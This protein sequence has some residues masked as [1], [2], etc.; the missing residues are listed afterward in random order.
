MNIVLITTGK[1]PDLLNQ[2]VV[3]LFENAADWESHTLTVV[4]DGNG[5]HG[6]I[7][8]PVGY[9]SIYATSRPGASAARNIG[10]GSIPKHRRQE[11]VLFLDDDV[12]MCKGWDE[13]LLQ[14]AN[15]EPCSIISG[16]GH[17]F[18][19]SELMV[20]SHD[21]GRVIQCGIGNVQVY[22]R[23]KAFF[24]RKPLVI[25]S[26]AMMMNWMAF[27]A[28]GPWDEPGGPGGSEDYALCMR[29]KDK[30]YGFA[31]TDPQ[32]VIH[33]GLISSKGEKIVG[34]QE[35]AEQNDKL[36]D[37]YGIRGKVQFG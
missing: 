14:L 3:S 24:Y 35:L 16:Y 22:D 29:A 12:Y 18:N 37:V 5:F 2:A 19:G 20:R 17:P 1:R 27:D 10:A 15:V 21:T 26:V 31:V 28:A 23:S 25:S 33:T 8:M 32:C 36:L 11:E 6:D 4:C 9:T 30:G 34:Y 13:K 7:R